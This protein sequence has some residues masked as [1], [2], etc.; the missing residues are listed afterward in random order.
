VKSKS[1]GFTLIELLV[2][3]AIIAILAA[4]LFPVFLSAKKA[5]KGATC[6]SNLQQLGKAMQMYQ[7]DWSGRVPNLSG[8][9]VWGVP[10][11]NGC[12]G[13][14][15]NLFRYH[16]KID[17]Y[18]C[19]SRDVNFAYSMNEALDYI[20][21]P[22]NPSQI[23]CIGEAPGCGIGDPRFA[24]PANRNG[25]DM[26]TGKGGGQN[27]GWRSNTNG[28]KLIEGDSIVEHQNTPAKNT[29]TKSGRYDDAHWIFWPGPHGATNILFLDGHVKAYSDWSFGAM[30]FGWQYTRYASSP[31]TPLLQ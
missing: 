31:K 13:W 15:E 9:T 21:T 20:M 30:T 4:I 8:D 17:L 24:N 25:T 5:A 22:R 1:A 26:S 23:L 29:T 14:C 18:R 16:K 6:R 19:P 7:D 3:I 10:K 12:V 28:G 27:D 2:V 11:G